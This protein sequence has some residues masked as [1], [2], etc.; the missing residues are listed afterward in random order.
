MRM[1]PRNTQ[2]Q[3]LTT[4]QRNEIWQIK[5]HVRHIRR[6]QLAWD[7]GRRRWQN[8]YW[9]LSGHE[10]ERSGTAMGANPSLSYCGTWGRG[11]TQSS[12]AINLR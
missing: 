12:V 11:Y 5:C 1:V 2:W 8:Q 4:R 6:R 9:F 10:A 3:S 7:G